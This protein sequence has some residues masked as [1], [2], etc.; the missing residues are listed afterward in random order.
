VSAS[1]RAIVG[2]PRPRRTRGR[3]RTRSRR[4]RAVPGRAV[5]VPTRPSPTAP[6]RAITEAPAAA[7]AARGAPAARAARTRTSAPPALRSGHRRTVGI[8]HVHRSRRRCPSETFIIS[9]SRGSFVGFLGLDARSEKSFFYARVV[10]PPFAETVAPRVRGRRP[11]AEPVDDETRQTGGGTN[12]RD[13]RSR[14]VPRR[15][16]HARAS[17]LPRSGRA[18][19]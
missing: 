4:T 19:G 15:A 17:R 6:P 11:V 9:A 7:A 1:A 10:R 16:G 5:H 2:G 8:S 14:A 13:A 3:G 18:R 12:G